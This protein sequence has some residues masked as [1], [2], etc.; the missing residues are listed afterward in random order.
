MAG[1]EKKLLSCTCLAMQ[2][3]Q[4]LDTAT[5]VELGPDGGIHLVGL[6]PCR[7]FHAV[8]STMFSFTFCNIPW[9]KQLAPFT[10]LRT[11]ALTSPAPSQIRCG[12]TSL[13]TRLPCF[14]PACPRQPC[15]LCSDG[16]P[17]RG[18]E[19][20]KAIV[21]AQICL[22]GVTLKLRTWVVRLDFQEV[23]II[24]T[25]VEDSGKRSG[26]GCGAQRLLMSRQT[27]LLNKMCQIVTQG[28]SDSVSLRQDSGTARSRYWSPAQER[29]RISPD[30]CGIRALVSV[31]RS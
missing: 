20:Q 14:A 31:Q 9:R 11:S 22:Y 15:V 6:E 29:L 1:Y 16:T 8:K 17:A 18:Q 24:S 25:D 5:E 2:S 30:P 10:G 28:C 13:E 4:L 7:V 19:M 12:T 27:G 3:V 23:Y 26:S 21:L